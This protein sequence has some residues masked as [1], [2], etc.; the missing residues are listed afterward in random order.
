MERGGRRRKKKLRRITGPKDVSDKTSCA[1]FQRAKGDVCGSVCL[2]AC[3]RTPRS[4]VAADRKSKNKLQMTCATVCSLHGRSQRVF[5]SKKKNTRAQLRHCT[6]RTSRPHVGGTLERLKKKKTKSH[7]SLF[8][9]PFRRQVAY[10]DGWGA[11]RDCRWGLGDVSD[12]K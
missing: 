9:P 4:G 2:Y 7:V 1:T 11:G 12:G 6:F 3:A 5:V 8:S 10:G